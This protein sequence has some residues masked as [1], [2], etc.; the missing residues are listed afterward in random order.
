MDSGAE[1]EYKAEIAKLRE[2]LCQCDNERMAFQKDAGLLRNENKTL[3]EWVGKL[4]TYT[5]LSIED[6]KPVGEQ[7]KRRGEVLDAV[8]GLARAIGGERE[9]SG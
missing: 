5:G 3:R 4:L 6:I 8:L 7:D 1:A 2:K 9:C